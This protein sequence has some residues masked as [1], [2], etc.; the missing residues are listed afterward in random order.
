MDELEILQPPQA[1]SVSW[2]R[3]SN[4]HILQTTRHGGCS[5]A[6]FGSLNLG[7]HVGDRDQDVLCNRTRLVRSF[8]LPGAPRY[9][10]QVHGNEVAQ[11]DALHVDTVPEADAAVSFSAG[12]VAAILSA[13][14]LPVLF[15][16]QSGDRIAAAHG[17]WRGLTGGV[18]EATLDALD[19][20]PVN[21]TVWIGP[22]IGRDQ[23]RVD[24]QVVDAATRR[25]PGAER[26]ATALADGEFLFD[27]SAYAE[28]ILNAAGVQ[29]VTR[30]A[31]C[32][33][34][35]NRFFSYR[36]D[37]DTGRMATLIWR[38]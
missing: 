12:T 11:L 25:H 27:L 6:P 4:V 16:T 37:G 24:R 8:G 26:F 9:L 38:E 33:A 34:S 32:T 29:S 7:L 19:V 3:P 22:G 21:L 35:D 5:R 14:C 30:S 36:R 23:Y 13:D 31:S 20:A 17:G 10:A 15:T 28:F 18:I 2:S 1:H